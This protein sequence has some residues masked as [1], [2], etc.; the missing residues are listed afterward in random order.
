MG[1]PGWLARRA[2]S[3]LLFP[4]LLGL[5]YGIFR[6]LVLMPPGFLGFREQALAEVFVAALVAALIT[7]FLIVRMVK[8]A[9]VPEGGPRR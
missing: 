7:D 2:L 3:I 1:A 4:V 6:Y 8:R 9:M 5:W